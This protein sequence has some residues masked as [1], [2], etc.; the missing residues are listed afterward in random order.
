MRR[1]DALIEMWQQDVNRL[2]VTEDVIKEEI[3]G[4]IRNIILAEEVGVIPDTFG[5]RD[6]PHCYG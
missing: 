4:H 3:S 2:D 1:L 6:S 5:M